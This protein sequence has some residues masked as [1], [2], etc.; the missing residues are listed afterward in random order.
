MKKRKARD[1][2]LYV[3]IAILIVGMIGA[4]AVHDADTGRSHSLPLKWLG[5]AG[6]TAIVFGYAIRACRR[7]WRM[8]RFW[9]LL[10]LFF[11]AH[12][13]LGVFVLTTVDRVALLSY[14]L[15]SGFEYAVLTAYLGFFLDSE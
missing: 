7:S 10:G 4:F 6:T 5:F 1:W 2:L 8:R 3:V 9:L 11:A 14:V 13:G 15:L 12:L